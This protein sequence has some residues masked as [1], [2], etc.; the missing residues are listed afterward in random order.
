MS[1]RRLLGGPLVA[2]GL[3][4]ALADPLPL[5][6]TYVDHE[7]RPDGDALGAATGFAG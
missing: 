4:V 3:L 5:S 6:A 2:A 7:C 1:Y